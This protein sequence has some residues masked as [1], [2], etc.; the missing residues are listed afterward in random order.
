MK[1]EGPL[2]IQEVSM[3]KPDDSKDEKEELVMDQEELQ[4]IYKE[5]K[6]RTGEKK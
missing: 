4:D 5:I 2:F 3:S 6:T 1:E